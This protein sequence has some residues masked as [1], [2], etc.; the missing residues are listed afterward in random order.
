MMLGSAAIAS[1]FSMVEERGGD[2]TFL[3]FDDGCIYVQGLS[4]IAL[5]VFMIIVGI[6]VIVK[7]K[8]DDRR[9]IAASRRREGLAQSN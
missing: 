4:S 5:G 1:G 9:R 2:R 3:C 6:I 8:K 7:R